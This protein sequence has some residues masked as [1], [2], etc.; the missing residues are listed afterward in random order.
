MVEVLRGRA[1][2][3]GMVVVAEEEGMRPTDPLMSPLGGGWHARRW[4]GKRTVSETGT[5][6]G[7]LHPTP[8]VVHCLQVARHRSYFVEQV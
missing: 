3:T 1:H 4:S 2:T 8:S 5:S 7:W 6:R